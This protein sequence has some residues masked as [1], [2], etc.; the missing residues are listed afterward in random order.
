MSET[1]AKTEAAA[2]AEVARRAEQNPDTPIHALDGPVA[3]RTRDDEHWVVFD[4]EG[5]ADTPNRPI[6]EI[7]VYD[8]VSF[9]QAVKQRALPGVDPVVYAD[10]TTMSLVAVLND[11]AADKAGWRDNRVKLVLRDSPEWT[12]WK[13]NE[14]TTDQV[15]F[16]NFVED[17]TGD[18]IDPDA[19][20]M[21]ALAQTFQA[22]KSGK[23]KSGSNLH[24]GARQLVVEDE[25]EATAGQDGSITIPK[26]MN[27][28][29]RPFF[30]SV[31]NKDGEFVPARWPVEALF[32]FAIRDGKLSIGYK[33][34]EPEEVKRRA[35]NVLVQQVGAGL[36]LAP[37]AA[38]APATRSIPKPFQTVS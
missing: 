19:A 35:Y 32:R 3:Q 38:P 12:R 11:D 10:E 17:S 13:S 34:V 6:G 20:T 9:I 33:L 2:V 29:L 5:V 21:L 22:T 7:S 15:T 27:I 30:G 18:F 23:F 37:L 1:E 8:A 14:G 16:A 31:S 25:V 4:P 36:E 24:N 28:A 26:S